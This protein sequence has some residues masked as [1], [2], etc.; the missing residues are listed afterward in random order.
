MIRTA[1]RLQ[2]RKLWRPFSASAHIFIIEYCVR[3][4]AGNRDIS[5]L[6]QHDMERKERPGSGRS[7]RS[8][9]YARIEAE[10]D[11]TGL[12]TDSRDDEVIGSGCNATP[13]PFGRRRLDSAHG[14]LSQNLFRRP[15]YPA[16]TVLPT[17][18]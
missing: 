15:M 13:T 12:K 16:V 18:T 5:D 7:S 8:L 17:I 3:I 11:G 14:R 6:D 4:Q 9:R 2:V 1:Y 10:D